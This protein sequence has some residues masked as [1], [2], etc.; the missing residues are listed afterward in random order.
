MFKLFSAFSLLLIVFVPLS[1]DAAEPLALKDGDRVVI[2]GGTLIEREQ[3]FGYWET[4]LAVAHADKNIRVR[5]LGW[6][7]DTVFGESRN[8]FDKNPKGFERL[9]SLTLELKPTVILLCYGTNES[10]AGSEG[11]PRFREGYDKLLEALKPSNAKIVLVSPLP[12]ESLPGGSNEQF[13]NRNADL[14]N[15]VT[16]TEE[17]AKSRNVPFVDLFRQPRDSDNRLTDNGMH[18]TEAGYKQTADSFL[19]ALGHDSVPLDWKKLEGLRQATVA[20]NE[21]F[22]HR[23]RPQNETY[24]FGFRKHEQGNN[25]KEIAEFDPLIDEAEAKVHQLLATFR[26]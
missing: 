10:F 3:K 21:L 24:L 1:V 8:G 2:I 6:S 13:E 25:A 23:W 19:K 15:Y 17:L 18:L 14:L 11:L 4:A 16:A 26:K 12:F 7:G 20:K 22:F 9:V 5:N